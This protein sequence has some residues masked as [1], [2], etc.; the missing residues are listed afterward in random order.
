MSFFRIFK[1]FTTNKST[2][3]KL[4][5]T[6][7]FELDN[8]YYATLSLKFMNGIQEINKPLGQADHFCSR[9]GSSV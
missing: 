1:G 7:S 3:L 2:Y 4:I 9:H 8:I 6:P 5:S